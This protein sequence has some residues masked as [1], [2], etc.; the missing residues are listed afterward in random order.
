MINLTYN[1]Q[2][3]VE[4]FCK[5]NQIDDV[6]NF[7][8]KCFNKGY[9]FEKY[10]QIG[11]QSET[12]KEVIVEKKV[13]VPVEVIKEVIVE[14]I[15]EVPVEV[16]KETIK[17]VPSEP[18][19]IIKEIIKE[20]PSE[21]VEVIKE[22][23]KEVPTKPV[24]VIKY[25]DK[26][27]I[28]EVMVADELKVNELLKKIEVL[29]NSINQERKEFEEKLI[30]SKKIPIIVDDNKQKQL[31]ETLMK[32]RKELKVKSDKITELEKINEEL[33]NNNQPIGAVYMK[34]SNLNN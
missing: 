27:I 29:E 10:P 4:N 15:V 21:P 18:I 34:G 3:D 22:I 30:E 5:L 17:E 32:L 1:Q 16:I 12:I 33:K 2:K 7:I 14:K 31:Q 20:V 28:K 9:S 11:S 6:E 19:E 13:E 23:I 8:I 24:E 25:V 26:E